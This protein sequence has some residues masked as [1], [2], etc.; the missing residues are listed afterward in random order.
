ML[1]IQVGGIH[2]GAHQPGEHLLEPAGIKLARSQQTLF[3]EDE[4]RIHVKV[5]QQ[6]GS[7]RRVSGDL[8]QAPGR[9]IV[10]RDADVDRAGCAEGW[11]TLT[12]VGFSQLPVTL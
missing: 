11:L 6:W 8:A 10:Q 7:H 4:N 9:K 12:M 2:L 5:A 1:E 3:G